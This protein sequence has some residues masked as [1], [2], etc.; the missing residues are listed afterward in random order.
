[1]QF[2]EE[3][4]HK[5][6]QEGLLRSL[7]GKKEAYIDFASNDYLG[8]GKSLE[9]QAAMA[10]E[11]RSLRQKSGHVRFGSG[12][13]RL[14]S[15]NSAYIEYL[16]QRLAS[17]H[18]T[19]AG[20][21]Y[22][23]GFTANL[24]LISCLA[25]RN[26]AIIMDCCAHA[27]I[28]DG[29]KL[30]GA[31]ILVYSPN[32]PN[33]LERILTRYHHRYRR[34]FIVCEAVNSMS[35]KVAPLKELIRIAQR[36]DAH[37]IVDEA[38]STGL[39]G[40][41]GQGLVQDLGLQQA[42]FARI[43]TFGKALGCQG[44]IIVGSL[45]LK[46]FLLNFSRPLIYTTAPTI[47]HLVHIRQAYRFMRTAHLQRKKLQSLIC[48]FLQKLGLPRPSYLSPIH[49]LKGK[50]QA[51][52]DFLLRQKKIDLKYIRYPTVS[53]GEEGFRLCLHSFNEDWEI[54]LLLQ[55]VVE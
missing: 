19:E 8:L 12:G 48:G 40:S 27:S 33:A 9:L 1:M 28:W 23:S 31:R 20:T 46:K 22:N 45:T 4:L 55:G 14:L 54:D 11:I 24:G 17:F 39:F 15:G 34:F 32:D 41:E 52:H 47:Y 38:H 25:K 5:R 30:S 37:V 13:S 35:G 44:A 51:L 16:E 18:Q 50:T 29:A 2:L 3:A 42:V 10:E 7:P 21:L 26:D 6:Q 36:F 43:H 53:R 49:F